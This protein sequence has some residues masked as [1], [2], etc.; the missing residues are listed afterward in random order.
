MAV[1]RAAP[2]AP[3]VTELAGATL[4]VENSADAGGC[5][6]SEALKRRTLALGLPPA[7]PH[8]PLAVHVL[9]RR[10]RQTFLATVTT[11]GRSSGERELTDSGATCDGLAAAT[12]VTLAVLLDL[13]PHESTV[14]PPAGAPPS[15]AERRSPPL[16]RYAAVHAHQDLAYGLL[17]PAPSLGFGADARVRLSPLDVMLGGFA[18]LERS[19]ELAPGTVEVGLAGGYFGV[20]AAGLRSS[21]VELGGCASF[22]MGSF[23]A[24]G[25]GYYSDDERSALW[26]AGSIGATLVFELSRHWA[27]RLGAG[28]VIPFQQ[29]EPVVGRVGRAY[30]APAVSGVLSFGPEVRFP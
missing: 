23:R 7:E 15:T 6:D 21:R 29:Q 28:V 30:D 27:V 26:L 20:C 16:F 5:P 14:P 25:H 19:V 3:A 18:A 13:R 22:L 4:E 17:G 2:A 10:E 8:P 12:A 9:F 1:A 24:A 11:A